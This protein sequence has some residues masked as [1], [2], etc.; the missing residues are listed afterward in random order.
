M[1][2]NRLFLIALSIILF[3]VSTYAQREETVLGERGWGFSGVWGGYHH[4]YTSYGNTDEFNRGGFFGFEFG[5]S[6]NVGWGNYR[7]TDAFNWQ[8]AENQR[9]NFKWNTFKLGYAFLPYKAIHPMV[10]FDF[11]RGKVTLAG[12]E[13]RVFVM[14]PSAGV[15][16]NV[17]RWFRLGLEGGY[18]FVNDIDIAAIQPDQ[19]A[20]AY[21]QASLKFGFSWGRFHKRKT[22]KDYR[23]NDED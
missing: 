15:E 1:K 8:G 3:S 17:F 6:L 7:V 22:D 11:G 13:D 23:R 18:R 4:Q 16:I 5:K 14:Q 20:G 2:R 19:I 21:G 10:N 12:A 9:F